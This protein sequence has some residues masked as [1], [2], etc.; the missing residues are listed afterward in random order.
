MSRYTFSAAL[1]FLAASTLPA[2]A[3][4]P[5]T[6]DGT[7]DCNAPDGTPA[8]TLVLADKTYAFV[9]TDGELGGYGTL[10]SIE[11]G[12]VLP[13]F[14]PISGPLRDK[15]KSQ[16]LVLRG[17]RSTPLDITGELYLNVGISTDG[18]GALDWDCARR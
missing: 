1:F 17:A 13:M 11:E 5:R 16:G 10:F 8:A 12:Y 3:G 14:A 6:A 7:W 4:H 15:V 18:S 2:L 9:Q